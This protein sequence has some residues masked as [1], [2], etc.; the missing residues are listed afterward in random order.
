MLKIFFSLMNL[1]NTDIRIHSPLTQVFELPRGEVNK[2]NPKLGNP[3]LSGTNQFRHL[4]EIPPP[5]H[6]LDAI[7][8]LFSSMEGQEVIYMA[9]PTVRP[10]SGAV[11]TPTTI[12]GNDTYMCADC[13]RSANHNCVG[14]IL[15]N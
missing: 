15:E 4:R 3:C 7:L 8:Q 13:F 14:R 5:S 2:G 12:L 1:S 6:P 10:H 9:S 11:H